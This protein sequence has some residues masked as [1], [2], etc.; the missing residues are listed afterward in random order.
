MAVYDVEPDSNGKR[1]HWTQSTPAR[2]VFHGRPS[3]R[4]AAQL[5]APAPSWERGQGVPVKVLSLDSLVEGGD[6]SPDEAPAPQDH[7]RIGHAVV[8]LA[9]PD[10]VTVSVPPHYTVTVTTREP[11][12]SS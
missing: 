9:G 3:E 8:T 10:H 12:R 1:W 5:H 11:D 6:L 4:Y 7:A 2:I